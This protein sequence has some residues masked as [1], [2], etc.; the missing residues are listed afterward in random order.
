M[1]E[2]VVKRRSRV[3]K[4]SAVLEGFYRVNIKDPDGR[5]AGDSG[6]T[7]NLIPDAGLT[8]YVVKLFGSTNGS[9]VE[10]M[11]LGT[12]T[13][14]YVTNTTAMNAPFAMSDAQAIAGSDISLLTS[15]YSAGHT[16]RFLATFASG[17]SDRTGDI[18]EIGL[19]AATSGTMFCGGTY[20]GSAL[21][22]NQAVNCTY[23]V[24][25]LASTS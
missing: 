24:V 18:C 21:A 9:T 2:K 17:N 20:T 6:W 1:A 12:G 7:H 11:Q 25:F 14:A 3:P 19:Y 23:D 8:L 15:V 16:V 5:V 13:T 4:V 22:S 10:F